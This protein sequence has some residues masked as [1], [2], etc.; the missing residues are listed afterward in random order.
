MKKILIAILLLVSLDSFS[1]GPSQFDN[2]ML[3][4]PA[5][6]K[7]AEPYVVLAAEYVYSSAIDK[8]DV[9]RMNAISFIMRWMQGTPDF[10]F[11][12]DE[13]ITKVTK[14]DNE[15]IGIYMVCLAKYALE[16][17]KGVDREEVKYNAYILMAEYCE[18][19]LNNYKI[20]GETKKMIDAKNQGKLKEYLDSK[21]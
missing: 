13:T 6:Y 18:N 4:K 9:H 16:K 11:T 21:K 14:S 8:D 5:D 20:R 12:F 1:Q 2:I 19:P 7:K 10:S 3:S 17:G 15:L